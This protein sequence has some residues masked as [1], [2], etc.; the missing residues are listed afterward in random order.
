MPG[1]LERRRPDEPTVPANLAALDV[2]VVIDEDTGARAIVLPDELREKANVLLPVS[3]IAQSVELVRPSIRS[4]RLIPSKD[5][6][7]FYKQQG[8]R[9]APTK[10]ALE[11]LAFLAGITVARTRPLSRHELS[12]YEDGSHGFEATVAIRKPDGTTHEITASKVWQP[13]VEK[14]KIG[15]STDVPAEREKRWLAEREHGPAKTESKATLRAIRA[16]LQIPHT[17]SVEDAGKPFVV[18]GYDL[19]LDYTDPEVVR[20]LVE[21]RDRKTADLYGADLE[22]SSAW[23]DA[24]GRTSPPDVEATATAPASEDEPTTEEPGA[25]APSEPAPAPRGFTGEEPP[26]PE[27]DPAPAPADPS[28]VVLGEGFEGTRYEGAPVS[29]IAAKGDRAYLR[30]L[31]SDAVQDE[32]VRAAAKV[33]LEG[34]PKS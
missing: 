18:V 3:S 6:P 11:M 15:Q 13:S 33:A 8:G 34:L 28:A 2:R 31:A 12:T 5:G 16:A 17:F 32:T 25:A 26:E 27:A 9:L 22:D 4:A 19:A 20:L 10:Q 29:E 30:W 14:Q 1:E 21:G 24:G 23:G 7:H